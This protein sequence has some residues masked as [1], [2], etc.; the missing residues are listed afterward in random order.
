MDCMG[1]SHVDFP[2]DSV[3]STCSIEMLLLAVW[4][5]NHDVPADDSMRQWFNWDIIPMGI[6][7]DS[8]T[9]KRCSKPPTLITTS[10]GSKSKVFFGWFLVGISTLLLLPKSHPRDRQ[11]HAHQAL[12]RH[13]RARAQRS[14]AEPGTAAQVQDARK[15]RSQQVSLLREHL[16]WKSKGFQWHQ[17]W[18]L[19][20]RVERKESC[21]KRSKRGFV[22]RNV[23]PTWENIIQNF[24]RLL[25]WMILTMLI[26]HQT[27]MNVGYWPAKVGQLS[28]ER[29]V[30]KQNPIPLHVTST[31]NSKEAIAIYYWILLMEIMYIRIY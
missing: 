8:T 25:I 10:L 27:R 19:F 4:I 16:S 31:N 7:H 26:T 18:H 1:V 9:S 12:H 3:H 28:Q 6:A 23:Q 5:A 14:A 22:L 20:D 13:I 30:L 24:T 11:I 21:L 15:L 2:N 17:K 29:L